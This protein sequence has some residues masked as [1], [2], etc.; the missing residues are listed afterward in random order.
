MFASRACRRGSSLFL[1][2]RILQL[3]GLGFDLHVPELVRVEDLAA[4]LALD[5]LRVFLACD[6]AN[7][8]VFAGSIHC[9]GWAPRGRPNATIVTG[10]AS[11]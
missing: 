4:F 10:K 7:S 1:E 9:Q 5:E 3:S 6:D 8:W 2:A 11:I